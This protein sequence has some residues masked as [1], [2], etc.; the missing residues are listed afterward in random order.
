[1]KMCSFAEVIAALN[2]GRR[3]ARAGW[4]GKG[5]FIGK[6]TPEP[7]EFINQPFLYIDSTGLL[8]NNPHSPKTRAPWLASQTDILASDWII[9]EEVV[10]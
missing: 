6:Y 8:G 2:V 1:M 7:T 10:K 5:I 3:A 9:I 4:N